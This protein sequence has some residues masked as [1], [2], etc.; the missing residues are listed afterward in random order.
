MRLYD[1]ISNTVE[2]GTAKF[3]SVASVS[4][5]DQ[6]SLYSTNLLVTL[7]VEKRTWI[8]EARDNIR[9]A[10]PHFVRRWLCIFTQPLHSSS[11]WHKVNNLQV[12]IFYA[13]S[14]CKTDVKETF[15]SFLIFVIFFSKI[16]FWYK[17]NIFFRAVCDPI[18]P[19]PP[20]GQDMT[21]DQFLSGV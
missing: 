6:A 17:K 21:Q 3:V 5:I 2:V 18:Y 15:L 10:S 13:S 7:K 4:R 19:N 9:H 12:L 11:I 20:L 1:N 16:N 8:F 14:S